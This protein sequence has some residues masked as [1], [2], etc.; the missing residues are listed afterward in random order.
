MKKSSTFLLIVL[1]LFAL[2]A[3][4]YAQGNLSLPN[5]SPYASVTQRIGLADM[6]VTYHRP[7]VNDREVWGA[8]VP[9]DEGKPFPWRAGANDNTT[10]TFSHDVKVEGK[11]L[12]AGTYGLHMIPSEAEW[13]IIFS[14]NHTSWGSFAYDPA[15][16]ALR[17]SVSPVEC[18]FQEYLEYNFRDLGPDGATLCLDW[19]KK[20]VPI[21][22]SLDV[23]AQVLD[24]IR[25]ELRNVQGFSWQGFQQAAN[26]CLQN[27]VNYEE[28]LGW[29]EQAITGGFPGSP[30]FQVLSTKSQLLEKTGK[31][32]EAADVMEQAMGVASN[33]ELYQYA[34]SFI[35]KDN[36]K[37]FELFKVTARKYPGTWI[38][39]AGLGAG[40]RVT[41]NTAEA[42]KHYKL[43]L[44]G[45]PGVWKAALEA[46]IKTLE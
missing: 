30:N 45:A 36:E 31:K 44:E 43:A 37:A 39:H 33:M 34:A 40:N 11:D 8:L 3:F 25:N 21:R 17:V 12:P 6:T 46:R 2:P 24:N 38:S 41:G 13:T 19:E 9:Y 5:V 7:A 14:Q 26:Y 23:H 4:V 32:D 42:L 35:P 22:I 29:I 27:E 16:D 20:R 28:G 1:C 18:P 15:E 10:V